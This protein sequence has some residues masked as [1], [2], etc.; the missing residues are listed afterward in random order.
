MLALR[1]SEEVVG[2]L[3]AERQK[4]ERDMSECGKSYADLE[5]QMAI[6]KAKEFD[7]LD[8]H[9]ELGAKDDSIKA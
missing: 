2:A 4:Y 9:R 8:L 6:F 3:S 7:R 5:K 1:E